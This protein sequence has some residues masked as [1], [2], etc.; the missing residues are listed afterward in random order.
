MVKGAWASAS[1][2]VTPLPEGGSV[3]DNVYTNKYFALT[4]VLPPS[5][6]QKY[7]GPPPSDSGY[8]VLVQI[9]P[10]DANKVTGGTILI[11]AQDLFFTLVPAANTLEFINHAE[12]KLQADYKVERAIIPSSGLTISRRWPNSIGTCWRHRSA[13]IWSNLFSPVA[14]PN[15]W[16]ALFK[17]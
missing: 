7:Y 8:Y 10:G 1:D 13:V 4:Y 14:T 6:T 9:R 12:E 5:W 15:F 16:R 3:A 2:S 11:V 17:T